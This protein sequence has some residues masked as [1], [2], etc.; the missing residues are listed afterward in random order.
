MSVLAL[1]LL[2]GCVHTPRDGAHLS[3]LD[4]IRIAKEAAKRDGISLSNYQRP[5]ARYRAD[6][7]TWFVFFDGRGFFRAPGSFFGV[8]V[9][10]QTG[11]ARVSPGM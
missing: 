4:A 6:D 8:H 5:E 11:E 2:A 1:A 9:D 10:D 7:R 3:K